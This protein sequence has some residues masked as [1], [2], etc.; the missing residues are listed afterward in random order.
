MILKAID[1]VNDMPDEFDTVS[2]VGGEFFDGQIVGLEEEWMQLVDAVNKRHF[3]DVWLMCTLTNELPDMFWRT[4][5]SLHAAVYTSYDVRGRFKS[6]AQRDR[7]FENVE[8]L[9]CYVT[10]CAQ[11]LTQDVVTQE[12]FFPDVTMNSYQYPFV[13]AY[14]SSM[15]YHDFKMSMI[16]SFPEYLFPRRED[17]LSFLTK[18]PPSI[19]EQTAD[20]RGDADWLVNVKS[21]TVLRDRSASTNRRLAASCG[22]RLVSQCY[23]DSTACCACDAEAIIGR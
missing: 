2:L 4:I 5:D 15:S 6:D 21:G 17:T 20:I 7:W 14:S 1:I 3:V 22:H 16:P 13:G 19:L 8:S 10:H 9:K 18:V 23:R 11:I 12:P